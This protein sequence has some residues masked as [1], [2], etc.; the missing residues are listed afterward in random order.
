MTQ[1]TF[2][3]DISKTHLDVCRLP[4]GV[5]RRFVYD[6]TGLKALIKWLAAEPVERIVYEPTGRYHRSFE[7]RMTEAG[8]PLSKVNPRQARRFAESIGRLAK[9]DRVDAAMLARMGTALTPALYV[10]SSQTLVDMQDLLMARRALI[11]DRT[12]AQNRSEGMALTLLKQ[13]NAARLKQIG[14]H[15]EAVED[16]LMA[17][18]IADKDLKTRF[19]ILVSIP[20]IGQAGALSLLIDMPE[21]GTLD[22]KQ[23]AALMGVAPMAKESGKWSGRASIKGGRR[24]LRHDLYMPAVVACRFNPDLKAFYEK[25]RA[26]GK[27]GKVAITAVMRKLTILANALIRK[28]TKWIDLRV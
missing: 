2:G 9:T 17:R 20:G 5:H 23:V 15:L 6:K 11:K 22:N 18:V 28:N 7:R 10:P 14:A 19:D 13:Q 25:L 21:L 4:D 26:A 12:A 8:F 24:D 16:E 3:V 1:F 27:S